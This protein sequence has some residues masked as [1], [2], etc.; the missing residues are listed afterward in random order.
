MRQENLARVEELNALV[1]QKDSQIA[2]RSAAQVNLEQSLRREVERLLHEID[3]RNG[4]LQNRNDELVRVKA[5]F[6]STQERLRQLELTA[7]QTKADA[8]V[9]VE[10]MRTEFQAQL[11]LLQAELSQKQWV[12]D[13][14]Q[15]SAS[16]AEHEFRQQIASLRQQLSEKE[17]AEHQ[18]QRD[19]VMGD[20]PLTHSQHE[21][22]TTAKPSS[23]SN[24]IHVQ[25]TT[26]DSR[27]RRWHSMFGGKRRWKN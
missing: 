10:T 19:F 8:T 17:S 5:D 12:L 21:A 23:A 25:P 14:R 16:G 4:I 1:N 9:E 22:S 11:A 13:E 6:D 15:A 2:E 3:E 18:L 26:A 24:G 20:K 27:D 7:A